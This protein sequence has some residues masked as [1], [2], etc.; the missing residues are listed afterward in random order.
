MQSNFR[1]YLFVLGWMVHS[2][3]STRVSRQKRRDENLA[4]PS[5]SQKESAMKCFRLVRGVLVVSL[6]CLAGTV[7]AD[8]IANGDFNTDTSGWTSYGAT[9]GWVDGTE[10][11]HSPGGAAF[12]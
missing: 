10:A 9:I 11:N 7:R 5:R 12:G 6:V 8:L 3:V 4:N 2:N 1:M